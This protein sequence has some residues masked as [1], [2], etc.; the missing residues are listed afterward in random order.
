MKQPCLL[1]SSTSLLVLITVTLMGCTTVGTGSG[2]LESNKDKDYSVKFSWKSK[3]GGQSGI[4][5]TTL[6]DGNVYSGPF[7]QISSQTE[8]DFIEPLWFGWDYGW[9]DW[10]YWDT[11][12]DI[13]FI[14]RYSGKVVANLQGDNGKHMRCRFHLAQPYKGMAGGG[15]G[16]CQLEK[17]EHINAFFPAQ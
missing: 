10:S 11:G 2:I 15:K 12:S 5:T 3:D 13:G 16:E 17:N 4:L 6:P 14:T 1:I 9:N 7:F 8:I